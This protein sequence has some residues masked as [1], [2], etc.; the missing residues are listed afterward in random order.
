MML[1]SPTPAIAEQP[2]TQGHAATGID[3]SIA[4]HSPTSKL[5]VDRMILFRV[6]AGERYLTAI[7]VQLTKVGVRIT[8]PIPVLSP[9]GRIYSA[10][11][12]DSKNNRTT[13][14]R[15]QHGFTLGQNR[16]VFTL[17]TN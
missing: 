14:V 16:H 4:K 10:T 7:G 15:I 17:I 13:R 5:S 11:W 6:R 9:L 3:C 2:H 12:L 8:F 1:M